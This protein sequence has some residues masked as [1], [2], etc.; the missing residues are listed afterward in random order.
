V[1]DPEVLLHMLWHVS[2]P[3]APGTQWPPLQQS[4]SNAQAAP[5]FT[6][7]IV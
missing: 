5:W 2:V 1:H 7:A 3:P 4:A 6:Q